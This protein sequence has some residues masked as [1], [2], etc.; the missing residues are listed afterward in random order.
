LVAFNKLIHEKQ[1][2]I[3]GL[4]NEKADQ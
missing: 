1:L 3:I 2:P 4:A